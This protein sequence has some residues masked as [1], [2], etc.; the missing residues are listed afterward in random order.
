[1]VVWSWYLGTGTPAQWREKF[2]RVRFHDLN[3][4]L[5]FAWRGGGSPKCAGKRLR[6]RDPSLPPRRGCTHETIM[7][8]PQQPCRLQLALLAA[9]VLNLRTFLAEVSPLSPAIARSGSSV[10]TTLLVAAARSV[11]HLFVRRCYAM[12]SHGRSPHHHEDHRSSLPTDQAIASDCT[13]EKY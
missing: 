9:A 10:H 11:R 13:G 1:M 7:L 12:R 2:Q 3:F 6:T 4:R 8:A 5:N